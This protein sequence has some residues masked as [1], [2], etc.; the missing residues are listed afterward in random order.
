MRKGGGLLAVVLAAMVALPLWATERP[1]AEQVAMA[2]EAS[3]AEYLETNRPPTQAERIAQLEEE[4]AALRVAMADAVAKANTRA[5]KRA[6]SRDYTQR[7]AEKQQ[8]LRRTRASYSP[9][10]ITPQL[11]PLEPTAVGVVGR[12]N[13]NVVCD[14]I[15][16]ADRFLGHWMDIHAEVPGAETAE[17]RQFL[18]V[19]FETAK[20]TEGKPFGVT[21]NIVVSGQFQFTDTE[22]AMR[23]VFVLEVFDPDKPFK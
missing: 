16:D 23:T 10:E 11:M 12:L 19:G 15:L 18:F 4:I 22:G 2:V 20:R 17:I 6:T 3:R 7:I 9:P 14:Q 13:R 21:E 5:K 1:S 8:E